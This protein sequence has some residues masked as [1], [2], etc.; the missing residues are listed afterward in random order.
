MLDGFTR[1]HPFDEH[2]EV[3]ALLPERQHEIALL[4]DAAPAL[5]GLLG[6]DLV[7]PEIGGCGSRLD[8]GEFFVGSG[9]LK[10]S[11]ADRPLGGSDLRSVS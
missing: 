9:C 5:Q 3:V 2:G 6:F 1:L 4:L 7:F 10:D 11:Y 8:A